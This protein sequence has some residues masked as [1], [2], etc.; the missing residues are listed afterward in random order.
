MVWACMAASETTSLV[1]I[2]DLAAE[3]KLIL[4]Q[5][6]NDPKHTVKASQEL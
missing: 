5:I 4:L 1:F 3:K 2:D 6:D